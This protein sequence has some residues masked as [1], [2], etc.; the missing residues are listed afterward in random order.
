MKLSAFLLFPWVISTAAATSVTLAD[1]PDWQP[2]SEEQTA[3]IR[4]NFTVGMKD[5]STNSGAG[6]SALFLEL[7]VPKESNSSK[8]RHQRVNTV[9]GAKASVTEAGYKT[10]A[11]GE[12]SFGPLPGAYLVFT[13]PH[14][15]AR[16]HILML[17]G[18][19][20]D[21]L[22]SVTFYSNEK[23]TTLSVDLPFIQSY[24]S[25]ISF[26]DIRLPEEGGVD[27]DSEAYKIGQMVGY[28]IV[29]VLLVAIGGGLAYLS[30]RLLFR[31][32]P[33]P[34]SQETA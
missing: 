9:A 21:K 28:L 30:Y 24:L 10:T 11:E 18:F 32:K 29:P 34:D 22:Y 3:P 5:F 17:I 13:S 6:A 4:K 27:P 33:E 14:P 23:P 1:S 2:L 12:A 26:S 31:K 20:Q 16:P 15:E 8:L 7:P 25:R 19:S